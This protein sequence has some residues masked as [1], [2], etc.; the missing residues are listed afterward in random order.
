MAIVRLIFLLLVVAAVVV[1]A[2]QNQDLLVKVTLGTYH[3]PDIPI[4]VTL[5]VA[6]I[7]GMLV[8]FLLTVAS[9]LRLRGELSRF[10]RECNRLKE[11]LNRLRNANLDKDV[12]DFLR[13]RS[14]MTQVSMSDVRSP[15]S[16]DNYSKWGE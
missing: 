8:Y 7:V 5:I 6:F 1:F 3:S 2:L 10:R 11:E 13:S 14:M 15:R 4:F 9:Q 16:D 12:D